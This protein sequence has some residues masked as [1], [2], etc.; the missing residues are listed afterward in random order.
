M[1]IA[2]FLL[3][4]NIEPGME[5]DTIVHLLDEGVDSLI[6]TNHFLEEELLVLDQLGHVL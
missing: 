6:V 2:T 3:P 4:H 1:L 5:R